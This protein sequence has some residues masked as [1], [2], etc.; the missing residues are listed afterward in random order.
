MTIHLLNHDTLLCYVNLIRLNRLK[1]LVS[2]LAI[3]GII[4]MPKCAV[5]H[6]T[7]QQ[8]YDQKAQNRA[9]PREF[10]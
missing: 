10:P 4:L 9:V 5:L 7:T 8:L 3:L 1:V 6:S 2:L